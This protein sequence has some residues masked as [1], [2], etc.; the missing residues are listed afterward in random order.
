MQHKKKYPRKSRASS[1]G[2]V[3]GTEG[4]GKGRWG[5]GCT[6]EGFEGYTAELQGENHMTVG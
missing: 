2:Y 5:E 4:E 1:K 3:G 6:D